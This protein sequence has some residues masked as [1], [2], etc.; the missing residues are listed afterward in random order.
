[1]PPRAFCDVI[2]DIG[3]NRLKAQSDK[4]AAKGQS[5]QGEKK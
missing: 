1:M 2:A 3:W 5:S 4:L